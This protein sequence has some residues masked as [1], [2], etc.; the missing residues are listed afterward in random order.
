MKQST[1]L[2]L[3]SATSTAALSVCGP[4]PVSSYTSKSDSANGS[5]GRAR[6]CSNARTRANT[7]TH[8]TTL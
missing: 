8:M 6:A 5:K 4:F 3:S 1:G 7:R 2:V